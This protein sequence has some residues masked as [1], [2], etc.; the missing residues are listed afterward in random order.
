MKYE[1]LFTDLDGTLLNSEKKIS[2]LTRNTIL[3]MLK[4]GKK[5]VL[6]SGR[7][8]YSILERKNALGIPDENVYITA[9]NGALLYDCM[10]KETLAAY[11]VP[12]KTAQQLFDHTRKKGI[13]IHTF[14]DQ[15]VISCADDEELK[16]YTTFVPSQVCITTDLSTVL[17]ADPFKLLAIDLN[18]KETKK[19]AAYKDEVLS[20]EL[21]TKISSAFSHAT[22]LE[23]FS[24]DAGKGNSVIHLCEILHIPVT[25]AAACGDEENDISM[26]EAA[27]LGIAMK[28][29]T[30]ITKD[31]ADY[32]TGHDN[33]Q[34]GISEVINRFF[35]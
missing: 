13:H 20:S 21:G 29:A 23:F 31:H 2:D 4:Q 32:I 19:L 33:D 7:P 17:T 11:P 10:K 26:L 15:L 25:S 1:I 18:E 30:R 3:Q 8:L 5:L 9:Y 14:Q 22:Y 28:N 12:I 34:D 27:G 6:A 35:L 24:K 16:Y